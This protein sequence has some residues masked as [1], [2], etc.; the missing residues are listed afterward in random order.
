M[1]YNG[2]M[3][4]LRPFL[5]AEWRYVLMLNYEVDP[6]VLEP[7][8]PAGTE[9][10]LWEGKALAS[11][12]GFLFRK[13]RL[14]GL[15]V[16]FHTNF[17]EINLRFYVRSLVASEIQRGGTVQVPLTAPEGRGVV[18]VKEIV[19]RFWIARF[20]RW[21]YGENYVALPTRHSIEERDG[22]LCPKG[23]V[24]YAWRH[25][26]RLNRL[27]GLAMGEPLPLEPGSEAEFIAEHYWGY[28]RL[29]TAKSGAYRV[30]HPRWRVWAVAQPYLL[31]NIRT[32][33]GAS[34]EPFLRRRPRSAFLAEGSEVAVYPGEKL[35]T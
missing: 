30:E 22:R 3:V 20:A 11:M 14:R 2:G 34:F 24:E 31:C 16:P 8:L 19:P 6:G 13:T 1:V 25:D 17:E 32:L 29:G 15:P 26:G 33:Y 35:K 7:L 23:L 21:F 10:D 4:A 28:T 5:T 9:L 27:G 12:V 18:F